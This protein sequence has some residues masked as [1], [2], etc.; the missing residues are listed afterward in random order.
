MGLQRSI[1]WYYSTKNREEV[2]TR[3]NALLLER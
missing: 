1:E 2:A 3:L